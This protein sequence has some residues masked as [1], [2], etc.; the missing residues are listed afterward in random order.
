MAKAKEKKAALSEWAAHFAHLTPWKND[1]LV[2]RNGPL[3]SGVCLEAERDPRMYKPAFFM[4]NLAIQSPCITISYAMNMY[5]HGGSVAYGEPVEKYVNRLIARSPALRADMSFEVF[6]DQ[7][8]AL[9]W[10]SPVSVLSDIVVLGAYCGDSESLISTL[11]GP[12]SK[13]LENTAP[14]E[15]WI[16]GVEKWRE[17]ALARLSTS[18]EDWREIVESEA[19]EHKVDHVEDMGFSYTR[20]DDYWA[21]L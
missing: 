3:L 16:G 12:V 4:H 15:S 6:I 19:S 13:L 8:R 9:D 2:A 1:Y 21:W 14:V 20:V 18:S 10:V 17:W 5:G 11:D 7:V